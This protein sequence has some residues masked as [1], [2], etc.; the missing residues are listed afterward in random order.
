MASD[1]KL[2][3]DGKRGHRMAE[4]GALTARQAR[5]VAA[6]LESPSIRAACKLAQ[7]GE[8][9]GWK[10]LRDP[11]VKAE[12]ARRQDA[13]L[14]MATAQVAADCTGSLAELRRLR[15]GA[16]S[17]HVRVAAARAILAAVLPMVEKNDLA[18][19]VAALEDAKNE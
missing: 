15:D 16:E 9:T 4:N 1:G 8:R 14:A 17:E 3:S 6:V 2:A 7:V 19:R 5:F 12:L 13:A 10:Y 18:A 11:A